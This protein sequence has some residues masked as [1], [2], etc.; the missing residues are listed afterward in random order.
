MRRGPGVRVG[1]ADAR[2]V[3]VVRRRRRGRRVSVGGRWRR[4]MVG[5]VGGLWL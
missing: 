3:V 2:G 4:S 5:E 1:A